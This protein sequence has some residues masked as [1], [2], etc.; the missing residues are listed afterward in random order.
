MKE[1]HAVKF[2][3]IH[4]CPAPPMGVVHFIVTIPRPLNRGLAV[5]RRH[6]EMHV[7]V[8]IAKVEFAL[9]SLSKLEIAFLLL[10]DKI[11]LLLTHRDDSPASREEILCRF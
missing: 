1:E 2:V 9:V 7:A 4:H 5:T 6:V 10:I 8:N 11:L 3:A